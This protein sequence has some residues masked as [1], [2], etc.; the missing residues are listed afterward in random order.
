MT[1]PF[2]EK[3]LSPWLDAL[4][5]QDVQRPPERA[6]AAKERFLRQARSLAA[7][8][9]N[10]SDQRH[11]GWNLI[12]I[13]LWRRK[14]FN[15]MF[16]VLAT[17]LVV[18]SLVLGGGGATLAA[19]QTSLP[20]Q[21]L[22][23][24]KL[25]SENARLS[26]AQGDPLQQAELSSRYAL[27]R[28]EELQALLQQGQA[29]SEPLLE[30][31]RQQLELALQR[32]AGLPDEQANLQ[33]ERLRARLQDLQEMLQSHFQLPE[34]ASP[35]AQQALARVRQMIQA[36]LR[37]L[38]ECAGDPQQLRLRLQTQT[39]T[40]EQPNAPGQGNPTPGNAT[41]GAGNGNPAPGSGGNPAPGSGSGNPAPGSGG[42]P[43]PGS[44]SGSPAP[45]SGGNPAP[46]SGG[47]PDPGSGGG[48]PDPGSGGGS[49][50]P[51]SGGGSPDPGSGG[52]N[53]APGS[54]G[55]SNQPGPGG[56][57]GSGGKKP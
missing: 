2:E 46:G 49:Q 21:P 41:P 48:N 23:G 32:S 7:P 51:G 8:V 33:L 55:G 25:A 47:N 10:P 18:A 19:A 29:P 35:A 40:Q 1:Q 54:G 15:P 14:E 12:P 17:I 37:L 5:Q 26:M 6:H 44:G 50:N 42:N 43:A 34:A 52:G 16:S 3:E 28:L 22:Y 36:R 56:G 11:K 38:E 39:Q 27:R 4:R 30:R 53:P 9:S 31:A 45:G 20:D 57:S 13:P 24:L